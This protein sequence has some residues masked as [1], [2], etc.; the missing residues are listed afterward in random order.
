MRSL[1]GKT[2]FITGASRGI[3]LSIALRAAR[4]GA[5]V[6]VAAKTA[7][8]NPKLPGTIFEAASAIEK[9][10]GKALAVQCDIR[11]VDQIEAAV[12]KGVAAFGGIDILVN[13]ASA[14]NL[15]GTLQLPVKSYDLMHSINTRG[16]YMTTRACLPHLLKSKNPH[17]LNLSPPLS[18]SPKWFK[19]HTA[20]TMAK[21]GMSMCVLG[22]AAEFSAQGVGVNALWPKTAIATAAVK[23]LLG[24]DDMVQ[25]SRT[26]EIM[27]DAAWA[28]LT[29]ESKKCTGNFFVDEEVLTSEGV[30][31]FDKYLVNPKYKDSLVLDFFLENPGSQEVVGEKNNAFKAKL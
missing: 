31:N 28:I 7:E 9:A 2:L 16:T 14:I 20:Y 11:D 27:A 21:Y 18:M 22:M 29:R 23:N 10:G 3:G 8:P 12:N 5:N 26:P 4:D 24:G 17:V 30:K 25:R 13:N 19:N 6:I 1:R 15:L